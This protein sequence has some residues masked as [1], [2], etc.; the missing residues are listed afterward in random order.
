M[1]VKN[2]HHSKLS[3]ILYIL[4]YI[5]YNRSTIWISYIFHKDIYVA[6]FFSKRT[7]AFKLKKLHI[8]FLEGKLF[9]SSRKHET[10]FLNMPSVSG[11]SSFLFLFFFSNGSFSLLFQADYIELTTLIKNCLR[12]CRESSLDNQDHSESVYLVSTAGLGNSLPVS[13][14]TFP[15]KR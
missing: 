9:W 10:T 1:K 13:S 4:L 8:F 6:V 12:C 3:N 2:D 5:I 15:K 14:Q 7:W 11:T